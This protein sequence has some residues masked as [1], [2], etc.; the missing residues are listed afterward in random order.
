MPAILFR[1]GGACQSEFIKILGDWHSDV[2][3]LY[4]TVP[5]SL[6]SK[7]VTIINR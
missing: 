7:S 1:R 3:L 5:L 2:V 6:Q 4:L